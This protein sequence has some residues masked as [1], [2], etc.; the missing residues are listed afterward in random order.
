M[1]TTE[2]LRDEFIQRAEAFE[3]TSGFLPEPQAI[4]A[5]SAAG[6]YR[7]CARLLAAT[8]PDTEET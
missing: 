7:E 6:T 8:T 1:T 5:R 2:R 4:A 3:A